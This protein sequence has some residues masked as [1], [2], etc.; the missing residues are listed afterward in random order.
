MHPVLPARGAELPG[1]H[2]MQFGCPLAFWNDPGSHGRHVGNPEALAKDP[3][4]QGTQSDS[5]LEPTLLFAVPAGHALH[6]ADPLPA[7]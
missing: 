2:A 4:V 6:A 3:A 5:L 7:A 1:A